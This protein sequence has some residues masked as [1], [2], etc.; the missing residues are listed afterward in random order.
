MFFEKVKDGLLLGKWSP[1]AF[2]TFGKCW[3]CKS[4]DDSQSSDDYFCISLQNFL[5]LHFE[6]CRILLRKNSSRNDNYQLSIVNYQLIS[7]SPRKRHTTTAL[8]TPPLSPTQQD[9]TQRRRK[10]IKCRCGLVMIMIC[11]GHCNFILKT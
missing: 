4:S 2:Q 7:C 8:T 9:F 10:G 5:C 1:S 11:K 3:F 6:K